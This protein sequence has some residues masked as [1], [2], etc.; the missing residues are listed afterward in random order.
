M[1]KERIAHANNLKLFLF[2][3]LRSSVNRDATKI[4]KIDFLY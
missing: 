2:N 3:Q 4:H 1:K